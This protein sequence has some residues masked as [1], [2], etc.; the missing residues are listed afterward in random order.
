MKAHLT[1]RGTATVTAPTRPRL[2]QMSDC[3]Q[4]YEANSVAQSTERGGTR[5]K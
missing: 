4:A 3:A 5:A 1:R 2:G